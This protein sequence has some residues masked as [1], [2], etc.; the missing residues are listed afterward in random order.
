MASTSGQHRRKRR[1]PETALLHT[2]TAAPPAPKTDIRGIRELKFQQHILADGVSRLNWPCLRV[3]LRTSEDLK[4]EEVLGKAY[5]FG[6]DTSSSRSFDKIPNAEHPDGTY[7]LPPILKAHTEIDVYVPIE[8]VDKDGKWRTVVLVFGDPRKL[9][10]A[11]F[12]KRE[13]ATWKDFDFPERVKLL[14]QLKDADGSK[15]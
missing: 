10:V 4:A 15:N 9:D 13:K 3:N 11:V 6:G 7:G 8:S 2:P 12:P 5:Y 14:E 1:L